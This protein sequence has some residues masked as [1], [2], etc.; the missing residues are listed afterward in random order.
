MCTCN[1]KI[2]MQ[3]ITSYNC[4]MT[5]LYNV[6]TICTACKLVL[7][8]IMAA[9]RDGGERYPTPAEGYP[10]PAEGYTTSA[11]RWS[12]SA[13]GW[14]TSA[15]RHR[16]SREDSSAQQATERSTNI[17]SKKMNVLLLYRKV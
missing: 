10:T 3:T 8:C 13:E 15:T 11:E 6:L 7:P 12:N 14:S 4:G 16:T 9:G 1:I 2:P 17:E 5:G